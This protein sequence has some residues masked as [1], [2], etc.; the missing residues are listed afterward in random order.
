MQGRRANLQ[1]PCMGKYRTEAGGRTIQPPLLSLQPTHWAPSPRRDSEVNVQ[2]VRSNRTHKEPFAVLGSRILLVF[3]GSFLGRRANL[4]PA[5]KARLMRV[6]KLPQ[7]FG[8]LHSGGPGLLSR[9]SRSVRPPTEHRFK[10][11]ARRASQRKTD[12]PVRGLR[13]EACPSRDT[14]GGSLCLLRCTSYPAD[15]PPEV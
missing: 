1:P 2:P 12:L 13:P 11:P 3:R 15:R 8:K 6:G 7:D 4:P 10:A 9:S 14:P 5:Q